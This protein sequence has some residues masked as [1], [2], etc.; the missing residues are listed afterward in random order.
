MSLPVQ[1]AADLLLNVSNVNKA[2]KDIEKAVGGA[3]TRGLSNAIKSTQKLVKSEY[4]KAYEDAL[5]VGHK[6][7]AAQLKQQF[8]ASREAI[9]GDA[10]MVKKLNKDIAKEQNKD[11]KKLLKDKRTALESNIKLSQASMRSEIAERASAQEHSLKLLNEGMENA[12]RNFA[13]KT[14]GAAESF[15]NI[16]NKGLTLDSLN[17]DDLM[18]SM[19]GSLK[20]AA[21]NMMR[22][23]KSMVATGGKMGGKMGSMVAGLGKAS[24]ALAGAAAGIAAVVGVLA[25]FAAVAAAA[26]GKTK[27]WNKAIMEGS[28]GFD[29]FNASAEGVGQTLDHIRTA[30]SRVSRA[31][32]TAG[33]EVIATLNAFNQSGM[34]LSEMKAFTGAARSVTAYTQVMTF[35]QVQTRA[36]GMEAGELAQLTNRMYEQYGFG[37]KE[38]TEQMNHFGTA[39]Q[40]AG[41][42]SRSFV[43]A[44]MEASANMALY[45]FRLEDTS[46]LLIGLTKI[47]GEDLGKATLGMEGTFRNMGTQGRYKAA[48]TGGKAL[49]SVID[50]GATRQLEGAFSDMSREQL[51]IMRDAGLIDRSA[52]RGFD[53]EGKRI[54]IDISQIDL[55]KLGELSGVESGAIMNQL[56]EAGAG[57]TGFEALTDLAAGIGGGTLARADALDE[58]DRPGEIA[59]QVAQAMGVL[60]FKDFESMGAGG[61]MAM[62]DMTGLQGEQLRVVETIFNRV[63]AQLQADDPSAY[64]ASGPGYAEIAAAIAGGQGVLT[65]EMKK[66][67]ADMEAPVL[68]VATQQLQ[69]LQT[70]GDVLG[71]QISGLLNW[72]GGGVTN[73][74]D[75]MLNW[76][77]GGS[78][79]KDDAITA[80]AAEERHLLTE[81]SDLTTQMRAVERDTSLGEGEKDAQLDQL[82]ELLE[83]AETKR[84]AEAGL[85]SD[86][87]NGVGLRESQENKMQSLYGSDDPN[88]LAEVIQSAVF[89]AQTNSQRDESHPLYEALEDSP[90]YKALGSDDTHRV[91]SGEITGEQV[92][93]AVDSGEMGDMAAILAQQEE[94][95]N[96][97]A[98]GIAAANASRTEAYG[99]AEEASGQATAIYEATVA[100]GTGTEGEI[101]DL[102]ADVVRTGT[103]EMQL[104]DA[105]LATQ[106]AILFRQEFDSAAEYMAARQAAGA[107]DGRNFRAMTA[108][109]DSD[110]A[111]RIQARSRGTAINTAS[112][113]SSELLLGSG[114]NSRVQQGGS[115]RDFLYTGDANGGMITHIDDQ[116]SFFGAKPG[117]AIDRLGGGGRSIVISNLTIN[118]SGNAQKTLQMVKRALRAAD[119]A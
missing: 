25:V 97:G 90:V 87:A 56:S 109:G 105:L 36:L 21:P 58:L 6:E 78:S 108:G 48:M 98:D 59:A 72:I 86:L 29:A 12:G 47:L 1:L 64:G 102:A 63:G 60:E 46:E 15:T 61:Q 26:Y 82:T 65:D 93:S 27:A 91:A 43:A 69:E 8:K 17:P 113:V 100:A 111:D 76:F 54:P 49:G 77:G 11:A 23:G 20:S 83:R 52:G 104:L 67:L 106:D 74:V 9:A 114:R 94:L 71:T 85:Q 33:E 75:G 13:E 112:Q 51:S 10:A 4:S 40:M 38:M 41:M 18:K 117:G 79:D 103:A 116:D 34:V 3:A 22:G 92:L 101:A 80:A 66:E 32:S 44:I 55:K 53:R 37:L 68:D 42:N 84:D 2:Q 57:I 110:L 118:E 5:R 45:N 16:V 19:A 31:W 35:A 14:E 96:Y 73:L 7:Q 88:R 30:A 39:A 28:S 62:E 24:M 81:L 99:A 107:P 115:V 50:A 70:I 119:R 89:A 95:G